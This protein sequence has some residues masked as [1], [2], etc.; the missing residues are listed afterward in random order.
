MAQMITFSGT[1]DVTP[2]GIPVQTPREYEVLLEKLNDKR[3]HSNLL[4][5]LV[6]FRVTTLPGVI[7][8]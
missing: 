2:I 5:F 1:T 3:T 6:T 4:D 8:P 7:F